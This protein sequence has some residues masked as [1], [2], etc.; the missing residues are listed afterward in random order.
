MI[1]YYKL[2]RM[3]VLSR[4]ST[5]DLNVPS[6]ARRITILLETSDLMKQFHCKNGNKDIHWPARKW[7]NVF[8]RA[9]C[10]EVFKKTRK[11]VVKFRHK[12]AD[13]L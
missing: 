11:R 13:W 9:V 1:P 4:Y 6:L 8:A 2:N 10:S 5:N 7:E 12:A 3:I